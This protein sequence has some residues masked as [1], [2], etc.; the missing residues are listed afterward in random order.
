MVPELSRSVVVPGWRFRFAPL[1]FC[2]S[3]PPAPT[4]HRNFWTQAHAFLLYVQGV[5]A[6]VG[7][8]RQEPLVLQGKVQICERSGQR[9]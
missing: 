5:W 3:F 8:P 9:L 2:I 1:R 4:L 6:R 7:S